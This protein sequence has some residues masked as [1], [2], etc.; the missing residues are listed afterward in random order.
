MK[1]KD[2]IKNR[3][4]RKEK[5]NDMRKKEEEKNKNFKMS[6]S[7]QE[8]KNNTYEVPSWMSTDISTDPADVHMRCNI[9][10]PFLDT[11]ADIILLRTRSHTEPAHL[12]N[13]HPSY[14]QALYDLLISKGVDIPDPY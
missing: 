6:A 13:C 2:Q 4:K 10:R 8:E 5:R 7:G 1:T 3:Q 9:I 11:P 12:N 14:A